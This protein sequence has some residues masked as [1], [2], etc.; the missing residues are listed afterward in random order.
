MTGVSDVKAPA[1]W[2]PIPGLTFQHKAFTMAATLLGLLLAAL[3]QTIVATAGPQIQ[4]ELHIDPSLYVWITTA[5]LVASTV[6]VPIWGKLS[7]TLGRR[8]ILFA[9]V[10]IF[11]IGSALCGGA[12]TSLQLILFRAVQGVGAGSLF[13]TAFAVIADLFSPVERGKYQGMF[14]AVFGLSS[15]VGPL[16]G[17]FITDH[18][19]WH[20][21]FFINLPIGAIALLFILARMPPLKRE[22]AGGRLDLLGAAALIIAIVP[23]L[24]ALSLGHGEDGRTIGWGWTS[25]PIAAMF[26]VFGIGLIMFLAIERRAENPVVDLSLFRD[27]AFLMGSLA[28]FVSGSTFLA[29]VVFLPLFMVNVVGLSATRSGLTTTPLTL[30]I[31]GGNMLVGLLVS[32]V[33]RYKAI[34][35]ASLGLAVASFA[36]FGFT[37]SVHSTQAEVS[38][39]MVLLGIGIGPSIPLFTLALQSAVPPRRIGVAT[40]MAMFSRQMGATVG[41]AVLG[42]VFAAALASGLAA[43]VPFMVAFTGA[44]ER[45]FRVCLAV[46]ALALAITIAMPEVPLARGAPRPAPDAA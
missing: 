38:L 9:G 37:L 27:R 46:S 4:R 13:T 12:Q 15:V 39:K 34:L 30:G 42:T 33:G 20:W 36:A 3:D 25:W 45:I 26:A 21:V 43:H 11:L 16:A 7:D 32:R 8:I 44:I 18:I 31:V 14:G 28:T 6:L 10:A 41:L 24:L 29:A 5:Y 1:A 17:G 23:L 40:S 35:V 2:E 22:G 19:G